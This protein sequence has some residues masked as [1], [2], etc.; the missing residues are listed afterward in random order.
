MG[1]GQ[2]ESKL[3]ADVGTGLTLPI[4]YNHSLAKLIYTMLKKSDPAYPHFLHEHG[5]KPSRLTASFLA[6]NLLIILRL[7]ML[8]RV[9]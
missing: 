9:Y 5:Y 2:C 7:V 6:E 4:N 3:G 8:C 1:L